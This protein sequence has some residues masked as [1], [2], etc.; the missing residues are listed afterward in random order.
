MESADSY[1][2]DKVHKYKINGI[3]VKTGDLICTVDGNPS[4][5]IGHFWW[6]VGKMI[7]GDVDH[8]AIYVG[9]RGQCVEAGAK[10]RVIIFDVPNGQCE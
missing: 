3:P 1:H 5:L 6:F 2:I 4:S 7:P 10:G 9:P 8:I